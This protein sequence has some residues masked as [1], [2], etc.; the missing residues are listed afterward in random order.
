ME[1]SPST[2]VPQP[3]KDM[4]TLASLVLAPFE[5]AALVRLRALGQVTYEPW[6][7]THRL[8]DPEE[9][10]AG[11]KAGGFAAVVI[12]ADFIFE[13][14]FAA[15]PG[16]RFVGV[17]RGA[18]NQV[19][20][21]AAT[22]HGVAVVHTPGR[23]ALA[24]AEHTLGLMLALLHRVPEAH[25][26]VVAG[27]WQDPTAAYAELQGSELGG[28]TVGIVGLGAIGRLVARRLRAFDARLLAYDPY[29]DGAA[30]RRCGAT[31]ATLD[32][33]L[34]ESDLVTLH[35]PPPADGRPLLA[36]KEFARMKPTALLV[37]TAS[38]ALVDEAALADALQRKALGGAALD[39]FAGQPLPPSSPFLRLP[40]VVLTPHIGGATVETVARHSAMIAE[41][42]ER[43]AHGRR[44][45][46]LAN[47]EVW[48]R[49]R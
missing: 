39:V 10:G 3:A 40:N 33:L 26:Y 49:G 28:K 18:L 2:R 6:T 1:M 12:E 16:L 42:L 36:A 8:R 38:G 24:V 32:A 44:P 17:C 22:R 46:H 11:L 37:N 21:E 20:L 14:T 7:T 47:P 29:L 27:R 13:E 48:R 9:L 35:A 5:A 15:A 45:R 19:D 4:G 41:D 25:Q 30:V 34:G 43:C 31:P 23:N